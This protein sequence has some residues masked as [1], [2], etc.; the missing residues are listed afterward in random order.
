[1]PPLPGRA[2]RLELLSELRDAPARLHPASSW[3][4]QGF[5][6]TGNWGGVDKGIKHIHTYGT[7]WGGYA[8]IDV[9]D[10]GAFSRYQAHHNQVYA[11][12][13]RITWEPLFDMDAAFEPV[14]R[15]MKK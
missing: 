7:G 10:P 8:L 9:D 12:I 3:R 6:R 11:R 1:M 15:G 13:A 14:I 4:R 2:P 5:A